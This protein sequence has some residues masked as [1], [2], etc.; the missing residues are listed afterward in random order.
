MPVRFAPKHQPIFVRRIAES[1]DIVFRD[2]IR[3]G[4]AQIP[5][6]LVGRFGAINYRA[7]KRGQKWDRTVA[8]SFFKFGGKSVG[9][10]LRADFVAVD[11][12]ALEGCFFLGGHL[13]D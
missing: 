4:A 8:V 11:G 12:D 2:H 3:H 7:C 10:V 1:A 13:F 9:P 6:E 5:Q